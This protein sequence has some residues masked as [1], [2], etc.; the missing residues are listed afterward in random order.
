MGELTFPAAKLFGMKDAPPG[1]IPLIGDHGMQHFVEN[2]GLYK[3][4]GDERGIQQ[5]VHPD[6]APFLVNGSK[7]KVILRATTT[8]L[9]PD[10][11]VRR[12]RIR[13]MARVETQENVLQ[14]K[15]T[16]FMR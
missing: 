13:K 6:E 3:P 16:P 8:A 15:E 4:K 1:G 11:T 14:I 12:E 10:D 5:R 7:N 2:D 9:A